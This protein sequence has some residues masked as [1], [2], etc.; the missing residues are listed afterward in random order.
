MALHVFP[1][2]IRFDT[3]VLPTFRKRPQL[4]GALYAALGTV[5]VTYPNDVKVV[6]LEVPLNIFLIA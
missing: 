4:I 3:D 2:G 6:L 5:Q 1:R